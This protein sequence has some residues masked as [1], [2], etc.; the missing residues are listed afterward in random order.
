MRGHSNMSLQ[1]RARVFFLPS[2][3][4]RG[5]CLVEKRAEEGTGLFLIDERLRIEIISRRQP[6]FLA[7]AKYQKWDFCTGKRLLF[8]HKV[9][10]LQEGYQTSRA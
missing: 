6:A 5:Q 3:D 8:R 9:C 4:E 1:H 10:R 7:N 2:F